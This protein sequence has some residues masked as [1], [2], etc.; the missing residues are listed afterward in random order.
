[1][2]KNTRGECVFTELALSVSELSCQ[3]A[4]LDECLFWNACV[5]RQSP[6]HL[7]SSFVLVSSCDRARVG[8]LHV[9]TNM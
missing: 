2:L 3:N 6:L 8:A 4:C 1:M 7:F 9:C 5:W